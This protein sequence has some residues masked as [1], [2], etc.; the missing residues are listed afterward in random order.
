M[1]RK[2][3]AVGIILLFVCGAL[4]PA[5]SAQ[6]NIPPANGVKTF[7]EFPVK[8]VKHTNNDNESFFNFAII[9]GTFEIR[10][11]VFPFLRLVVYNRD[12]WEN[13][14]INVIGYMNWEHKFV[15]KKAFYIQCNFWWIGIVGKHRLCA[16]GFRD[17]T[18]F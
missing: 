7:Q 17:V 13:K 6:I 15:Y 5:C 1:K 9:W 18:A 14:T 16:L 3:V 2:G 12:P 11:D 10:Y 8:K 4:M